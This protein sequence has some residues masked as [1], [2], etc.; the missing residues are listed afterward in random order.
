VESLLEA[1]Y[2]RAKDNRD[3]REII[4]KVNIK[5]GKRRGEE[6]LRENRNNY[7]SINQVPK[8]YECLPPLK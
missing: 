2:Y 8:T 6:R 3:G 4:Q 1:S 7:Q 5:G